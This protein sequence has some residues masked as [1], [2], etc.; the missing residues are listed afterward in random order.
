MNPTD[1]QVRMRVPKGELV[2]RV[3]PAGAKVATG[4]AVFAQLPTE[5]VGKAKA[6]KVTPRRA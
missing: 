4:Q 1:A 6:K 5:P 3:E 2:M